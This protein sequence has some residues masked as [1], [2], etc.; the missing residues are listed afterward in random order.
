MVLHRNPCSVGCCVQGPGMPGRHLYSHAYI[1]ALSSLIWSSMPHISPG[2]PW[3]C[4]IPASS[5]QVVES[6]GVF[7][8]RPPNWKA[9][10]PACLRTRI[11]AVLAGLLFKVFCLTSPRQTAREPEPGRG[12]SHP[13][14]SHGVRNFLHP[15][16]FLPP[17]LRQLLEQR[18]EGGKRE[19]TRGGRTYWSQV[20][21]SFLFPWP[22]QS[23]VLGLASGQHSEWEKKR[24]SLRHISS[25]SE[26]CFAFFNVLPLVLN[27]DRCL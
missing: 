26:F 15:R 11:S 4:I 18:K 16:T 12:F 22:L 7:L 13:L 9:H 17:K 19:E 14:G 27:F 10:T 6:T 2:W 1:L 20:F 8:S 3:I 21:L 5:S 23:V 24:K 25:L